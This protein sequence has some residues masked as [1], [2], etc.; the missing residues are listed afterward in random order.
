[1]KLDREEEEVASILQNA[2][3]RNK[4]TDI[5]QSKLLSLIRKRP[6]THQYG[7]I[8]NKA[9]RQKQHL[10]PPNMAMPQY[11]QPM[12]APCLMVV[13]EN[14]EYLQGYDL[15]ALARVIPGCE[16]SLMSPKDV[17]RSGII[18]LNDHSL[19]FL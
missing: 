1:M 17:V 6:Y 8:P 7:A 3:H 10:P 19:N 11:R 9:R 16:P 18:I 15:D 5:D 4:A 2:Q 14:V 13:P 12:E